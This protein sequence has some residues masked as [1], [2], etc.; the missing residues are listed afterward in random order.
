MAEHVHLLLLNTVI[1]FNFLLHERAPLGKKCRQDGHVA[2]VEPEEFSIIGGDGRWAL[3]V[4][5]AYLCNG[6]DVCLVIV[7]FCYHFL[8]DCSVRL[9]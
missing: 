8:M 6:L 9:G 2:F 4:M 1:E 3:C 5:L 7:I